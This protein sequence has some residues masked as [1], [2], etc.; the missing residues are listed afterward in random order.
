MVLVQN[1]EAQNDKGS[2]KNL[3]KETEET[4]EN[5]L[6]REIKPEIS[7]KKKKERRT[8]WTMQKS[9]VGKLYFR[10]KLL[11]IICAKGAFH[12]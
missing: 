1:D 11:G 10:Q 2:G 7:G 9:C 5:S 6:R 4:D 3:K 8:R 12:F